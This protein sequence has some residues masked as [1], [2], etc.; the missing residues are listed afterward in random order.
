[1]SDLA[2]EFLAAG[3]FPEERFK[4]IAQE[5]LSMAIHFATQE[6]GGDALPILALLDS[7]ME[8]S[9]CAL[10]DFGTSSC[11]TT[12]QKTDYMHKLGFKMGTELKMILA[13][14]F[15]SMAWQSTVPLSEGL[16]YPEGGQPST[17]P[18]REE[19]LI[20]VAM[21]ICKR[22]AQVSIPS[23]RDPEKAEEQPTQFPPAEE[24]D[25]RFSEGDDMK[26]VCNISKAFWN[27]YAS[28][29]LYTRGKETKRV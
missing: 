2:E 7:D 6:E 10:A 19:V 13:T 16:P 27:G 5:Q 9:V 18:D 15:S 8:L 3:R 17:D 1:M 20:Y 28:G 22:M 4:E 11:S 21:S 23:G 25:L 14:F 24:V 29:V 26:V 12:K